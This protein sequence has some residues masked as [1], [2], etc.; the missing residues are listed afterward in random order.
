[1]TIPA[2]QLQ[3]FAAVQA[4]LAQLEAEKSRREEEA[5][6]EQARL[7]AAK[8][9]VEEALKSI[10]S[11]SEA[12]LRAEAEARM[13]TEERAKRYALDN[14]LAKALSMHPILPGTTEQLTAILRNQLQVQ[15]EGES[16]VVRTSDFVP[17]N[18]FVARTLAKP[19][20]AHFLR[21]QGAGGAGAGGAA[22]APTPPPNPV[23]ETQPKNFGEAIILQMQEM[24]K[25]KAVSDPRLDMN[26]G[27]GLGRSA[28]KQA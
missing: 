18:D 27:F 24:A 11:Q 1:V 14:E 21:P 28:I 2:E 4:R 19:E 6:Q 22:A 15:T 8:G 16:Y 7:L 20:F 25:N 13:R 17:A 3:Q 12:K 26:Q 9:Q 23:L 5:Q 10:Q